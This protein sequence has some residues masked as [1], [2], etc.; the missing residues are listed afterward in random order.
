MFEKV[1]SMHNEDDI[2]KHVQSIS[3]NTYKAASKHCQQINSPTQVLHV[4]GLS[5][6][7]H[8]V[9]YELNSRKPPKII[10]HFKDRRTYFVSWINSNLRQPIPPQIHFKH[11]QHSIHSKQISLHETH[12]TLSR[13]TPIWHTIYNM[14]LYINQKKKKKI[15]QKSYKLHDRNCAHH[16]TKYRRNKW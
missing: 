7:I 16:T 8:R 5:H 4:P 1:Y 10:C 13:T 12:Y 3:Q 6:S 14:P 15:L 11:L 2:Y 9:Y